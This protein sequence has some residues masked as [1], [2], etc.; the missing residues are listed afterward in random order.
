MKIKTRELLSALVLI[1]WGGVMIYLKASGRL[2]SFLHPNFHMLVLVTGVLL[3]LA[4]GCMLLLPGECDSVVH[5]GHEEHS[6]DDCGHE[7]V[8]NIRAWFVFLILLLPFGLA[9]WIAPNGYGAVKVRNSEQIQN[10]ASIPSRSVAR[11][12]P[13]DGFSEPLPKKGVPPASE[14]QIPADSTTSMSNTGLT[15]VDILAIHQNEVAIQQN[16]ANNQT[17]MQP[18]EDQT[19]QPDKNGNIPATVLDLFCAAYDS[20]GQKDYIGKSIVLIGQ[21][22]P[23]LPGEAGDSR[24]NLTRLLMVCCAA[25][26]RPVNVQVD[27]KRLPDFTKPKEMEWLEVVGKVAFEKHG[28]NM[29][30]VVTADKAARTKAPEETFLY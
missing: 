12:V 19:L 29:I 16:V 23:L 9:A 17:D 5:G 4:A 24:F 25:D 11:Q 27:V 10:V 2:S 8:M 3:L 6:H 22:M 20:T 7:G 13:D 14:E 18:G 21:Y 26:A 28:D 1:E 15:T 30:A